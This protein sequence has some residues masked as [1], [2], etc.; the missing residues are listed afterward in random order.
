M[1]IRVSSSFQEIDEESSKQ[2]DF[3]DNGWLDEEGELF[4]D[5]EEVVN[6][7]KGSGVIEPSSSCFHPGVW[8]D[9]EFQQDVHTGVWRNE[10]YFIKDATVEEQIEIYKRLFPQNRRCGE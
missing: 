1:A 10:S 9:T 3:S 6:H 2:G 5:V 8:Y 4:E 7:L